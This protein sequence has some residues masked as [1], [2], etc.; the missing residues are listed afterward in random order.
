MAAGSVARF[1]T[2]DGEPDPS[3]FISFVDAMNALPSVQRA[4]A[5]SFH[6]LRLAPGHRVLEVGSG[7]GDDARR[8]AA[9]VGPSGFVLGV[10]VSQAMVAEARRRAEGTGL[11]VRFE[12]GDACALDA[13]DASFDSARA[14]RVLLHLPDPLVAVAE[15]ARVTRPGGRVVLFDADFE[16]LIAA[17]PDH[18]LLRRVVTL[19]TDSINCGRVGR[20]LTGLVADAGLVDIGITAAS[21]TDIPYDL[22]VST[23]AGA[24]AQPVAE[25]AIGPEDLARFWA[26]LEDMYKAGRYF[27]SCTLFIVAATVPT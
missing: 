3:Y 4:K 8:I 22:L 13:A 10:D 18:V 20:Q 19:M 2:V 16:T 9:E 27:A 21:F 6:E 11:P 23:I 7:T 5:L 1:G 17:H 25:E 14:A 15:M 12:T 26:G 24:L